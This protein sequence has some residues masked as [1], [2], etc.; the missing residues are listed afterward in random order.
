MSPALVRRCS[1]QYRSDQGRPGPAQLQHLAN[2]CVFRSPGP[3]LMSL[4]K[5]RVALSFSL[6]SLSL[7]LVFSVP[8]FFF[9][10]L[11]APV[12][13][14]PL[15]Q[16]GGWM[17]HKCLLSNFMCS[18]QP[19]CISGFYLKEKE[20]VEPHSSSR[21]MSV[22]LAGGPFFG[23]TAPYFSCFFHLKSICNYFECE[24]QL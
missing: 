3:Y 16:L 5:K 9:S 21:M 15:E 24:S 12:S 8:L 1:V 11:P 17:D 14:R 7:S 10:C 2:P 6:V 19:L 22:N 20:L 13:L 23:Y 4:S 18:S